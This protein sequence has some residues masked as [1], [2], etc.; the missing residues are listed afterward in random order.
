LREFD[1]DSPQA[2]AVSGIHEASLRFVDRW[3]AIFGDAGPEISSD[4]AFRRLQRFVE[5]PTNR[6]IAAFGEF[7]HL[8]HLGST[9]IERPLAPAVSL[10]EM[11]THPK[12]VIARYRSCFWKLGFLQRLLR[13]GSSA[14][15]LSRVLRQRG[16][17]RS[18]WHRVRGSVSVKFAARPS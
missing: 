2:R 11:L 7:T 9:A 17:V 13:S 8:D 3:L 1:P 14:R 15:V 10:W 6:E 12:A 4:D 5:R 16:R 18:I